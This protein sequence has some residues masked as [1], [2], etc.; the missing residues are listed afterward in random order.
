MGVL[1]L[2]ACRTRWQDT[3]V[4]AA[5]EEQLQHAVRQLQ[6]EGYHTLAGKLPLEEQLAESWRYQRE[7]DGSGE[8]RYF[9]VSAKSKGDSFDAARV[10]AESLAKVQLA[11][12]M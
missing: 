7:K 12:L 2:F 11:G 5:K 10:Q 1:C 3:S 4:Q 6:A 8:V 9:V